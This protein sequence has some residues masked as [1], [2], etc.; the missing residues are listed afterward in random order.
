MPLIKLPKCPEC[1]D[2]VVCE[3][4]RLECQDCSLLGLNNNAESD[5]KLWQLWGAA[6]DLLI[7]ADTLNDALM[8]DGDCPAGCGGS[9]EDGHVG[10]CP[11]LVLRHAI[12]KAIG[13]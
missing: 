11:I 1:G 8:V 9:N 12:S 6:K 7:A 2:N 3:D 13:E 4:N 5:A 10:N